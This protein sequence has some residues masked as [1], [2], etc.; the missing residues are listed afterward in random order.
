MAKQEY[1]ML[2]QIEQANK[3]TERAYWWMKNIDHELAQS[4]GVTE[5]I[6]EILSLLNTIDNITMDITIKIKQKKL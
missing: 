3:E 1:D 6:K 2:V 4:V 5:H